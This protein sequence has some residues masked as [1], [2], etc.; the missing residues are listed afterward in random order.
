MM[1]DNFTATIS[2]PPRHALLIGMDLLCLTA[3]TL[4]IASL[5]MMVG[6]AQLE[7]AVWGA[8]LVTA[9]GAWY[10]VSHYFE[11]SRVR[12][13]IVHLVV[14][15][16]IFSFSV[17]LASQ[18]LDTTRDGQGYHSEAVLSLGQG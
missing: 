17:A 1:S 13:W 11:N 3:A 2:K 14:V 15:G 10:G 7:Y 6:A 12:I 5:L 9:L 18:W 8:L 16:L 4:V